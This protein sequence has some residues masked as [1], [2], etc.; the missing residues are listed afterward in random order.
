MPEP[1]REEPEHAPTSSRTRRTQSRAHRKVDESD[2]SGPQEDKNAT[3]RHPETKEV[4]AVPESAG[5]RHS[6]RR[7]GS[8]DEVLES[9]VEAHGHRRPS[10]LTS[11]KL[12]K[13]KSPRQTP[14]SKEVQR[15]KRKGDIAKLHLLGELVGATG[16]S[17]KTLFCEWQLVF[18]TG[19]KVIRGEDRGTTHMASPM[20]DSDFSAFSHPVHLSVQSQNIQHWPKLFVRVHEHHDYV[21]S[22]T[23]LAYG[24]C[25]LPTTPG[26]HRVQ[27]VTWRANDRVARLQDELSGYFTSRS[28]ELMSDEYVSLRKEEHAASVVTVGMGTVHLDLAMLFEG[29]AWSSL[30]VAMGA[31]HRGRKTTNEEKVAQGLAG[32]GA[33]VKN[34]QAGLVPVREEESDEEDPTIHNDA[35]T[36]VREAR[37][38]RLRRRQQAA[39]S[40]ADAAPKEEEQGAALPRRT[41]LARRS[42]QPELGESDSRDNKELVPSS[43]RSRRQQSG[44]KEADPPDPVGT[45]QTAPSSRRTPRRNRSQAVADTGETTSLETGTVLDH[46]PVRSEATLLPL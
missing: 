11:M 22:D 39:S 18:G 28:A 17:R 20:D 7:T 19:W 42:Q 31:R 40:S 13:V 34:L 14:G 16:F 25:S 43:R 21:G 33:M 2:G 35:L 1:E 27:C 6:R 9:N 38:T 23:F 29:A 24:I 3:Q 26:T 8:T 15:P 12:A 4:D 36:S 46:P 10:P 30:H 37:G 5:T 41:R 45:S 32:R 44:G